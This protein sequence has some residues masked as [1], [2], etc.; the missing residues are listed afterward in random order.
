M[1]AQR[2]GARIV[3]DDNGYP[4]AIAPASLLTIEDARSQKLA[5]LAAMRYAKAQAGIVFSGIQVKTEAES[6]V[7]IV[8]TMKYVEH[9]P[10]GTVIRWKA[11]DMSWH[12]LDLAAIIALGLAVG[13]YSEACWI[14]EEN[15]QDAIL[16]L[17]TREGI[18]AYD[19]TNDWPE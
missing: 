14:A 11:S 18:I 16:S 7:Q 1:E 2:S 8:K 19:I 9:K 12:P 6:Q 4:Q 3:G 10:E 17:T 13:D 15:H 5:D